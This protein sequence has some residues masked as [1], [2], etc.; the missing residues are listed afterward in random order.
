MQKPKEAAPAPFLD[1]FY[2]QHGNWGDNPAAEERMGVALSL[3]PAGV[4]RVLDVGCG[5]GSFLRLLS[6]GFAVGADRS[7]AALA[8]CPDL[9]RVRAGAGSLPF[10]SRA[11]ELVSCTEVL[12]HLPE[13]EFAKAREELARVAGRFI[14][15]SVPWQEQLGRREARCAACGQVHHLYGHLRSFG[16]N[17]LPDLFPGF[18]LEKT[19][20]AGPVEKD[21]A[22]TALWL[23]RRLGRYEWE[24]LALC[25]ACGKSAEGPPARSLVSVLTTLSARFFGPR[26][27]KWVCCL[28]AREESPL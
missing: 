15:V 21:F 2:E 18:S 19:V 13:D 4:S 17:D 9:L 10:A 22:K 11:L 20:F 24:P 25:P 28:Y 16:P 1:A 27:R 7:R 6:P 23:R 14:L 3:V 12:E 5:E 8:A 26:H